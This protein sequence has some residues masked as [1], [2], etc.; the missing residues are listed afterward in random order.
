MKEKALKIYYQLLAHFARLYIKKHK[1]F[2][3]WICGSVWKTSC[4]MIIS[5]I[6]KNTL[7]SKKVVTSEKNFNGEL[8][9]SLSIFQ[10]EKF[11]PT[12]LCL[13]KTFFSIWLKTF[14]GKRPYDVIFLEYGIDHPGE[15]DFLLSIVKPEIW[16]F[17]SIDKVHSLQ[18]WDP[19]VIAREES[20]LIKNTKEIAFLNISD[21][22]ARQLVDKLDIDTFRYHTEETS[23]ETD[24][25]YIHDKLIKNHEHISSRATLFI[26]KQKVS[27]ETNLIG[28]ENL[29]YIW[30]WLCITDI[31]AHRFDLSLKKPTDT[32][33]I[34]ITLQPWRFSIFQW[35][36]DS[37]LID[38]TYNAAPM[39]MRKVL[40]SVYTIKREC[41]KSHKIIACLGDMRE[42]GDFEEQ[43]HRLLAGP[44]SQIADIVVAV[45]TN[46]V[47]HLS[48]E[49][50]KIWY[51]AENIFP[52]LSSVLAWEKIK[53]IIK[54]NSH[55]NY[56]VVFKWSQNTIFLEEAVKINLADS[57]KRKKLARQ[58]KWRLKTKKRFFE[59]MHEFS[60]F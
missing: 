39:S 40:D 7:K 48:D 52:Y 17:T 42:L 6:L 35:F 16:I 51:P 49:L 57:E 1:P 44:V 15:M 41:L 50:R 32:V 18:F 33:K 13:I 29:W 37:I 4:R 54:E 8:G 14:F 47:D 10:I 5:Q 43:E 27:I 60:A 56:I 21:Q 34:T 45:G 22:Y 20:L 12:I 25:N 59:T 38:S 26:K 46:S 19:D 53:E 2:V 31:L 9:L 11:E 55:Q 3:I 30:I 58:S 28:K 23:E 24:I 36:R